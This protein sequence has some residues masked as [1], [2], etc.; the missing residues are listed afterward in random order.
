[1]VR[2]GCFMAIHAQE[3]EQ[4]RCLG[5][6]PPWK[7]QHQVSCSWRK[8]LEDLQ[9]SD[10]QIIQ[11]V[12]ILHWEAI[13]AM[14]SHTAQNQYSND[15]I[16]SFWVLIGVV[17]NNRRKGLFKLFLCPSKLILCSAKKLGKLQNWVYQICKNATN[18]NKK[19]SDVS[20]S[21]KTCDS[22]VLESFQVLVS[23]RL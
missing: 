13:W 19:S 4:D 7:I 2:Q 3:T 6:N 23:P 17:S 15:R 10:I 5:K 11:M 12:S 8:R 16:Y 21:W 20:S 18:G 22:M 9:T 1:M 14:Q